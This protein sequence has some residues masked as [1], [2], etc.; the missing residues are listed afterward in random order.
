MRQP[1]ESTFEFLIKIF[2]LRERNV[3]VLGILGGK[4]EDRE[5]DA[6]GRWSVDAFVRIFFLR[7][8]RFVRWEIS[9][10]TRPRLSAYVRNKFRQKVT[11]FEVLALFDWNWMFYT[12]M[13]GE[14]TRDVFLICF[15]KRENDS[16]I[17]PGRI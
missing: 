15:V 17:V 2:H 12:W 9:S 3:V 6:G 5:R 8:R 11:F 14:N 13:R 16:L 10:R 7:Y 1:E 4:K